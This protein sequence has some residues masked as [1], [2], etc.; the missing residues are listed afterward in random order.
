MKQQNNN[1]IFISYIK[2]TNITPP[3]NSKANRGRWCVDGLRFITNSWSEK[4]QIFTELQKLRPHCTHTC[5]PMQMLCSTN[6]DVMQM[7]FWTSL[8]STHKVTFQVKR[9]KN[10]K[11]V[12]IQ[13]LKDVMHYCK[14]NWVTTYIWFHKNPFC[15]LLC[16]IAAIEL[17]TTKSRIKCGMQNSIQSYCVNLTN[18]SQSPMFLIFLSMFSPGGI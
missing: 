6:A 17:V 12:S 9:S 18:A 10:R 7:Y 2:Y 11:Y 5:T 3:A 15:C 8:L 13:R 14:I 1:N 4:V 16:N